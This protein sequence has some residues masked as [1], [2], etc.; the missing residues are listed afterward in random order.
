MGSSQIFLTTG[1]DQ[2]LYSFAFL[3]NIIMTG[4]SANFLTPEPNGQDWN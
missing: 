4:S 2:H 1:S 3:K